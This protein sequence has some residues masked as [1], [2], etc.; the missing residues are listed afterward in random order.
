MKI[1]KKIKNNMNNGF[2]DSFKYTRELENIY[3]N[4]IKT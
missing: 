2:F 4:I 3:R 1:Q